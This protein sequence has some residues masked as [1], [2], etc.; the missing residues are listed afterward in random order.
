M[1]EKFIAAVLGAKLGKLAEF[2]PLAKHTTLR[3]GGPARVFV[4]PSSKEAFVKVIELV[5]ELKLD[6][7]ILGKGSNLL[8][9]DH[10]FE[11]VVIQTDKGMT[12]MSV[13]GTFVTVGAGVSD[14]KLARDVAKLGLTGLE[15]LSGIPG[16]I[17]GAVFMN[18][19]AYN[20]E[21]RD[22]VVKVQ[23]MNE[24]NELVWLD[25]DD[26]AF[27]YRKSILQEK[28]D[29]LVVEVVLQLELGDADEILATI[30]SRKEK[31]AISQPIELPSAG[32]VFRNPVQHKAW[33]LIA[34]A[35]LRGYTVGGAKISEKHANFIV[36]ANRATA[37]DIADV[38]EHVKQ[39]IYEKNE[40]IM[41]QEVEFFNWS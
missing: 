17:G 7:K 12:Q 4:Q 6:F 38:I 36:N 8:A 41:H 37:Q 23:I 31:R 28:P 3:V 20:K 35:G 9:S 30:K 2:E 13:N 40:L 16:T 19:G 33:E 39:T 22:V 26:L 10:V 27:S 24:H 5:R 32:S 1:F 18:A 15:F 34:E 25:K 29:W 14:V 11:G 21:I